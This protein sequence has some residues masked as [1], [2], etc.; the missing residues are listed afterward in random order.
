MTAPVYTRVVGLTLDDAFYDTFADQLAQLVLNG[1][2]GHLPP[3]DGE[4]R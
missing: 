2:Q 3:Q 1:L 4:E